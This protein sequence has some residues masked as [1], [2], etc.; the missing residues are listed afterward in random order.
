M[1][2]DTAR[3]RVLYAASIGGVMAVALWLLF[4]QGLIGAFDTVYYHEY[5]ARLPARPEAAPELKLHAARDFIYA[6][7]FASLPWVAFRGAYAVGLGVL[8]L[9]EIV[10]T[11][12][13]FVV[14]DSV[15]RPQGGVFK[16][17][18]VMHAIMGIVYG[19]MLANLLPVWW[20]WLGEPTALVIAPAEVPRPLAITLVLMG[21]GVGASGVRDMLAAYGVKAAQWPHRASAAAS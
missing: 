18:R 12:A 14:E 11:L 6:A 8:L 17:E 19:A 3:S 4:V 21:A 13:D 7:I 9:A 20:V 2:H 15:R 5:R 16:G 10:I 1:G